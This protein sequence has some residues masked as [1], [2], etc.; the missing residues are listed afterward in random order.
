MDPIVE[1][2]VYRA[3]T[4]RGKTVNQTWTHEGVTDNALAEKGI[5]C[6]NRSFAQYDSS[7]DSTGYD[8]RVPGLPIFLN[9]DEAVFWIDGKQYETAP[10]IVGARL[11]IDYFF[12]DGRKMRLVRNYWDKVEGYE[13]TC[14]EL[15]KHLAG[16][17]GIMGEC[18]L[19]S[20][21]SNSLVEILR[22]LETIYRPKKMQ[23]GR[24]Y[25]AEGFSVAK[26]TQNNISADD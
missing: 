2:A 13:P 23:D 7:P 22:P 24:V 3:I 10:A 15:E 6:S 26:P 19:Q 16:G 11:P 5:F 12:G 21:G 1:V 9:F 18:F 4:G 20:L 8:L 25:L 14:D 17:E